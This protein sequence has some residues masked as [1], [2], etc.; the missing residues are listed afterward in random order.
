MASTVTAVFVVCMGPTFDT[1]VALLVIID[2]VPVLPQVLL[3]LF[4]VIIGDL[5]LV[6]TLGTLCV[7]VVDVVVVVL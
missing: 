1:I 2:A 7:V 5:S 6:L 3:V 4:V